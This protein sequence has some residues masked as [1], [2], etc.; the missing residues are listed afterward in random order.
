MSSTLKLK[1]EIVLLYLTA[2]SCMIILASN[3]AASKIWDLWGIPVDGGI[4]LFPLSYIITDLLIEF[5]GEW[6]ANRVALVAVALNLVC[7]L[8]LFGVNFLPAYP[9]WEGQ[10]SFEMIFGYF[11]RITV[12]SLVSYYVSTRVNNKVFTWVKK[13]Q[14]KEEPRKRQIKVKDLPYGEAEWKWVDGE[15]SVDDF[16]HYFVRAIKSSFF[17]RFFD[18]LIFETIAFIGI[19]PAFDFAK[20]AVFAFVAGMALETFL[21]LPAS[22]VRLLVGKYL[23]ED[24]DY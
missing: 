3:L 11:G 13:E 6:R 9:D 18:S 19:L 15:K 10:E 20:Q 2:G 12:A 8:I 16:E 1:R 17:A 7:T 21:A 22:G 5:Y 23:T 4:V 14:E 24:D